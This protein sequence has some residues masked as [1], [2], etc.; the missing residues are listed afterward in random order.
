MI[1]DD[2]RQHRGSMMTLGVIETF[3]ILI[4]MVVTGPIAFIKV[5]ELSTY[6]V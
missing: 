4:V 1:G 5:Y 2:R 6:C 3:H